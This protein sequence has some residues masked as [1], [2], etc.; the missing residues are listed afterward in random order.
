MIEVKLREMIE[1]LKYPEKGDVIIHTYSSDLHRSYFFIDG[2]Y[3]IVGNTLYSEFLEVD[4]SDFGA[5]VTHLKVP[6]LLEPEYFSY[7]IYLYRKNEVYHVYSPK[8]ESSY[9]DRN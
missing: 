6:I 1:L 7:D 5:G 4:M 8:V 3:N 2:F 9:Y